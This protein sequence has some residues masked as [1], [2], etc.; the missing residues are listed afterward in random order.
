MYYEGI[1]FQICLY[2]WKK[3]RVQ[4]GLFHSG[5]F[6]F[7]F[8]CFWK[9]WFPILLIKVSE[10]ALIW[11]PLILCV[12]SC[13]CQSYATFLLNCMPHCYHASLPSSNQLVIN[14]LSL[15]I[16]QRKAISAGCLSGWCP[17]DGL[18]LDFELKRPRCRN[19]LLLLMTGLVF[20]SSTDVLFKQNYIQT[21]ILLGKKKGKS[22]LRHVFFFSEVEILFISLQRVT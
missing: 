14:Q 12:N 20:E 13:V 16:W 2:K 8:C 15:K 3:N 9:K 7:R 5:W 6:L 1:N 10:M 22:N 19:A 11:Q 21:I 4:F 17:A 18:S